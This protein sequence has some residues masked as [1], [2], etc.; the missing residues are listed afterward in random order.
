MS[1]HTHTWILETPNG[2]LAKATCSG[3]KAVSQ[4]PNS[5]NRSLWENHQKNLELRKIYRDIRK[6]K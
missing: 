4:F 2:P 3:C 5:D 6:Y 1:K